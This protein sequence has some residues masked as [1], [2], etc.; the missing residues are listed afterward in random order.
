MAS[1]KQVS[2]NRRNAAKGTGPITQNGKLQ[3]RRNAIRHGLTAATVVT[4]IEDASEFERFAAAVRS[5]YQPVSTVEQELVARLASLLWRLRRASLIETNLFQLQG[6][7]AM[8]PKIGARVASDTGSPGLEMLYRLL[9]NSDTVVPSQVASDTPEITN[10]ST[11]VADI[12][13]NTPR[14]PNPATIFLRLCNLNSLPIER[15]NRYETALWRQ[16]AQTLFILDTCK[17]RLPALQPG[18]NARSRKKFWTESH[19]ERT[20]DSP[21]RDETAATNTGSAITRDPTP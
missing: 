14:Q 6:R 10:H 3:S 5:D 2:A 20:A 15:I 16:V 7:L 18:D 21:D 12:G 8:K 17:K 13:Q 19:A 4:T 11:G 9:R 1:E